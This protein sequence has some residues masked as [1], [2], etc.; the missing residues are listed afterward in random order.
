M[1]VIGERNR[2][3]EQELREKGEGRGDEKGREE[4]AR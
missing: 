2:D 4:D 3:G 1:R